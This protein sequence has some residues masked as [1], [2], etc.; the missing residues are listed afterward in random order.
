[1]IMRWARFKGRGLTGMMGGAYMLIRWAW[2][3]QI[4]RAWPAQKC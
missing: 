4:K 1:M 3:M 2:S